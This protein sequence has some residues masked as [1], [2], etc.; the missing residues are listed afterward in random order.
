MHQYLAMLPIVAI[1]LSQCTHGRDEPV[2]A[3]TRP[4]VDG[5]CHR[6]YRNPKSK[7]LNERQME[8]LMTRQPGAP[9]W[10]VLEGLQAS[11][12]CQS[13]DLTATVWLLPG[14]SAIVVRWYRNAFESFSLMSAI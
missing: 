9:D 14:D 2:A 1:S 4:A 13:K 11:P 10:A 8:W 12:Y 3:S 7:P 6:E 5:L